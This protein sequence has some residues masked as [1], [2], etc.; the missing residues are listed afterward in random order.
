V[1]YIAL[2]DFLFINHFDFKL[3]KTKSEEER[4]INFLQRQTQD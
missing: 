2:I 4:R 1:Y 3:T